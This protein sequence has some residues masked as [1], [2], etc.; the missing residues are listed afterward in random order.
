MLFLVLPPKFWLQI[1][2]DTNLKNTEENKSVRK[3][4]N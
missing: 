4:E 1:F 2:E 3:I